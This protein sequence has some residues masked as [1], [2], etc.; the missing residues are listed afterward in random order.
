MEE[1]R[2]I[3]DFENYEVS[4]LGNIRNKTTKHVLKP[5]QDRKG[6]YL[7]GLSKNGKGHTRKVHRLVAQAF[8]PNPEE[9]PQVDHKDNDRKNNK[10]ENLRWA[11]SC[12]NNWNR[13]STNPNGKG[14]YFF[15][16]PDKSFP[17]YRAMIYH[18][19]VNYELGDFWTKEEAQQAR[20]DKAKEL[21]GD[22]LNECEKPIDINIKVKT[23]TK[24][25]VNINIEIE[26][27]DEELKEL[28]K[29]LEEL[30]KK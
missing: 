2:I 16:S 23:K 3:K 10:A 5:S 18:K 11:S 26:D 14:V 12:E 9:K 17:E 29:E 4:N 21:F 30:M 13:K 20:Y 19:G 27:D 7:I 6:Y 8:V 25:K 24:R 22:F 28:E 15:K 1:Y